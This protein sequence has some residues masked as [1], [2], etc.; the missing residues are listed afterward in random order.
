VGPAEFPRITFGFM[1]L[2][3]EPFLEYCLRAVYPFAHQIIVSEGAYWASA[4]LATPDGHSTDR[5]LEILKQFQAREDSRGIVQVLTVDGLWKGHTHQVQAFAERATGDYLWHVDCDEFYLPESIQRVREILKDDP[6]ITMMTFKARNFIFDTKYLVI[7]GRDFQKEHI[8]YRRLFKWG[9]GYRYVEQEPPT[10]HDDHG[11]DVAKLHLMDKDETA[12]RGLFMYHYWAIFKDKVEMKARTYAR[13][14]W[15]ISNNMAEWARNWLTLTD[16]WH[17][18][19]NFK[20]KTWIRPYRGPHPPEVERMRE[21]IARGEARA[22]L[23]DNHDVEGLLHSP[24]YRFK[25]LAVATWER[26]RGWVSYHQANPL[27]RMLVW[28]A[29]VF[30]DT[31][32]L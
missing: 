2:N 15:S 22:T 6:S 31:S 23:R 30:R 21:A 17:L 20:H 32:S 12:R 1:V 27:A 9:P 16:P 29:E 8:E 24:S 7:S 26:L 5:T 28:V 13:R 10:V 19:S 14:G 18:Q 25:R 3:A 11:R 4:D